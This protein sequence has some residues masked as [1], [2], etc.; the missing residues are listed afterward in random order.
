MQHSQQ[1]L[2][3]VA[4]A[5]NQFEWRTTSKRFAREAED[6]GFF[7]SIK[8]YGPSDLASLPRLSLEIQKGKLRFTGKGYGY[9]VWK[10]AIILHHLEECMNDGDIL[11]YMDVGFTIRSNDESRDT[12]E[13]YI[14]KMG[15]RGPL[16]FQLPNLDIHHSKSDVIQMYAKWGLHYPKNLRQT[17]GGL[18]FWRKDS[19]SIAIA[20][21]WLELCLQN[22]GELINDIEQR[23]GNKHLITHRHDQSLLTLV[24]QK[25]NCSQIQDDT[26]HPENWWSRAAVAKPF[27]QTRL[28]G[29]VTLEDLRGGGFFLRIRR[30]YELALF[31]VARN[32]RNFRF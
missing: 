9:W 3:L 31:R 6:S 4:F 11:V 32:L 19:D 14:R 2:H 18:H 28:K 26:Y 13:S 1:S 23:E 29:S 21:T 8:V 16:F 30:L 24:V 22:G 5:S 10:P 7:R 12:L 20:K 27:L 25:K 15:N 17:M